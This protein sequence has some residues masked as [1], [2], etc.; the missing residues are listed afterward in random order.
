MKKVI[1]HF[2]ITLLLLAFHF[3]GLFAQPLS[4]KLGGTDVQFVITSHAEVLND[5][6]QLLIRRAA[7][8]SKINFVWE[9]SYGYGYEPFH[10]EFFSESKITTKQSREKSERGYW[11][12]FFDKADLLIARI[13]LPSVQLHTTEIEGGKFI[14]ALNLK[15]I[16]ILLLDGAARIDLVEVVY[17]K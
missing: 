6:H 8:Y 15:D 11:L 1:Y 7:G 4:E 9:T 12:T 13:K 2:T 17:S 5:D 16:P 3:S 10:L 14:Y